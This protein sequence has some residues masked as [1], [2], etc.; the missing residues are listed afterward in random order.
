MFAEEDVKFYLAELTLALEH[1]HNLGIVYRDLKP[2]NIL[3]DSVGHINIVDF[4]LSKESVDGFEK[5]Y[6]FCGT[7]EYMAPEVVNRRGHATA[8]D[9]WSVGVLMY[10]MSTG[11]LPFQGADRR[12]TMTQILKAKL[13]MP[14][15]LSPEAQSLLRALFKRNPRNRLGSGYYGIEQIKSHPFFASI[16]WRRLYNHP[17]DETEFFDTEF[18]AKIPYDSPA[19]PPS[20]A[21]HELFRG[22]SFI[23]SHMYEEMAKREVNKMFNIGTEEYI[24]DAGILTQPWL[25]SRKDSYDGSLTNEKDIV[26]VMGALTSTYKALEYANSPSSLCPV[27]A[28]ALAQRRKKERG[29]SKSESSMMTAV[30]T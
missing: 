13:R 21:A 18:T 1:L 25:A 9:W 16:N 20:A 27:N 24:N 4:G 14:S 10:E 15:N 28:S 3:L 17:S 26:E 22:F 19:L 2:E 6:S 23:G 11:S 7:V 30:I 5:T 29:S 8:A 12:E